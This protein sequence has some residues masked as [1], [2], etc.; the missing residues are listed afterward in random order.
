MRSRCSWTALAALGCCAVD[1][2]AHSAK[3]LGHAC[4]LSLTM[5][6]LPEGVSSF[7]AAVVNSI[8]RFLSRVHCAARFLFG[9]NT[10][11]ESDP[12]Q[13]GQ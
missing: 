11:S 13:S 12:G 3:Q 7:L 2:E 6:P 8:V 9:T 10:S 5:F 1:P 4:C